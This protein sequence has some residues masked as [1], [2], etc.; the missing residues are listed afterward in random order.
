MNKE[1]GDKE[2]DGKRREEEDGDGIEMC[3]VDKKNSD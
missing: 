3:W 2:R 1:V